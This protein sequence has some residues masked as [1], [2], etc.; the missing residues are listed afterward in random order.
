MIDLIV[1]GTIMTAFYCFFMAIYSYGFREF[2]RMN[3]FNGID[4]DTA[5][6]FIKNLPFRQRLFIT[7]LKKCNPTGKQRLGI[8]IWFIICHYVHIIIT[9]TLMFM[10]WHSFLLEVFFNRSVDT[11]AYIMSSQIT[12]NNLLDVALIITM[13][14]LPFSIAIGLLIS[15]FSKN[16]Y[17][18]QII[19]VTR[20]ANPSDLE[21]KAYNVFSSTLNTAPFKIKENETKEFK[22]VK[23]SQKFWTSQA[24]IPQQIKKS[25]ILDINVLDSI[26]ELEVGCDEDNSL[27]I[28]EKGCS[29]NIHL[30]Y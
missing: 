1:F 24:W 26:V 13:G 18:L 15:W 7:Y 21:S 6:A 23:G 29:T 5:K 8:A 30:E 10:T 2:I 11:V 4:K 17:D 16:K 28:R 12:Y 20:G 22:V 19:R 9:I 25:N 14:A 27:W 3:L